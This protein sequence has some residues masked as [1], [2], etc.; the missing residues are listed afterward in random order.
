MKKFKQFKSEQQV[1]NEIG[2]FGA[3]MMGAMGI[4]GGG[5]AA[6]KMF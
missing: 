6:Y 1:I 3:A 4:F 2:P 5:F